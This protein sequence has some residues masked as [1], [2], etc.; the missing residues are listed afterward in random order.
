MPECSAM[1]SRECSPSERFLCERELSAAERYTTTGNLTAG[2]L[3]ITHR[4]SRV[5]SH[6]AAHL[7]GT[8]DKKCSGGEP[9]IIGF[10]RDIAMQ[11]CVH[12]KRTL[13]QTEIEFE[14]TRKCLIIVEG[15]G[16][17]PQAL[18]ARVEHGILVI[19]DNLNHHT[20]IVMT[21]PSTSLDGNVQ[22]AV[23]LKL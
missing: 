15:N 19:I 16:A 10:I 4:E 23:R 11:E 21:S 3:H 18:G 12:V 7:R 14:S 8:R 9:A 13:R 5:E 6:E 17:C 22:L 2:V 1:S 20:H